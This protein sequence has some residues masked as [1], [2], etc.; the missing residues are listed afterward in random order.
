VYDGWSTRLVLNQLENFFESPDTLHKEIK[1]NK[2]VQHTS[3]IDREEAQRF[4]RSEFQDINAN[5]L[6][7]EDHKWVPNTLLDHEIAIPQHTPSSVSKVT[8]LQA[9]WGMVLARN[10]N[11]DDVVLMA[12]LTGRNARVIGIEEMIAPTLS[13]VPIRISPSGEQS[14]GSYLDAIQTRLRNMVPYE[15]TRKDVISGSSKDAKLAMDAA[16]PFVI[17][18]SNPYKNKME[19]RIGLSHKSMIMVASRPIAFTIDCA[20][21]ET[22]YDIYVL[23]NDHIIR[24]DQVQH[25]VHQLERTVWNLASSDGSQSLGSLDMDA[26]RKQ[27]KIKMHSIGKELDFGMG[28]QNGRYH[29]TR[30]FRVTRS[31]HVLY[32]RICA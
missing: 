13:R 32:L 21:S 18:P 14:V 22:G 12:T 27:S 9:A 7:I 28:E 29:A 24:K 8:L 15:Q 31:Y 30:R 6:F 3:N 4:W 17:H 26:N 19:S 25:M 5:P 11:S 2:F 20:I 1:F 16:V 23:F 10:T